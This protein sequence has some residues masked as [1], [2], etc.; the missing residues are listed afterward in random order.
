MKKI[1]LP[2]RCFFTVRQLA[3]RWEVSLDEIEHLFDTGQLTKR[4]KMAV[5]E[6]LE[7]AEYTDFEVH[8][9]PDKD[10]DL[11]PLSGPGYCI[12]GINHGREV[13]VK[14]YLD[15][16]TVL[17]PPTQQVARI[18]DFIERHF[19]DSKIPV[20]IIDDVLEFEKQHEIQALDPAGMPVNSGVSEAP[21]VLSEQFRTA[22]P[23][24]SIAELAMLFGDDYY[25][26]ADGLISCG[27]TLIFEGKPADISKWERPSPSRRGPNG[28]FIIYVTT[29]GRSGPIPD[30]EEVIVSVDAIP[31]SWVQ[32]IDEAESRNSQDGNGI[33]TMSGKTFERI[34]RAIA[35]FPERYPDYK[36]RAPKLDDDVR[37]WLKETG[38]AESESERR[39]FGAIIREHFQLLPDT[40]KT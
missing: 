22:K 11:M 4:D 12:D 30:P 8:K 7:G 31:A 36:V 27:A 16:E 32:S 40:L 20:V 34:Q 10:F 25:R 13:K 1:K 17:L 9:G 14:I 6:G 38:L 28:E 37:P 29:G 5:L 39:V 18:S 35:A 21:T 33:V 3:D 24:Y 19:P 2:E 26:V 15:E 23:Y